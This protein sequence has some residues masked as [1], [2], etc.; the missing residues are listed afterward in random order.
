VNVT[1]RNNV[2]SQSVVVKQIIYIPITNLR[3]LKNGAPRVSF[4]CI[5]LFYRFNGLTIIIYKFHL[6]LV[7]SFI[8]YDCSILASS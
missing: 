1:C 4:L 6:R 8:L 3:L 7:N 5:L 2:S